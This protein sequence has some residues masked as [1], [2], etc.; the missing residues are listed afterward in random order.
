[1]SAWDR[2]AN[3]ICLQ[4]RGVEVSETLPE[5]QGSS[6]GLRGGRGAWGV[7]RKAADLGLQRACGTG[8]VCVNDA[9][10]E[11]VSWCVTACGNV[12]VRV[13]V[14]TG[15]DR[16]PSCSS[17]KNSTEL[18]PLW[19]GQATPWPAPDRRF[20]RSEAVSPGLCV[21]A[22]PSWRE[23]HAALQ[24]TGTFSPLCAQLFPYCSCNPLTLNTFP[25][26]PKCKPTP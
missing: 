20:H 18:H 12:C 8:C 21:S 6:Q 9:V 11:C 14:C 17:I 10:G 15:V 24:P 25:D 7:L 1:M 19:P 16:E 4:G 26:P 13:S 2:K 22:R 23:H 5:G 3:A